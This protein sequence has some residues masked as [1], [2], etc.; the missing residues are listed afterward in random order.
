[1]EPD[2]KSW[3][4]ATAARLKLKQ[5]TEEELNVLDNTE[6]FDEEWEKVLFRACQRDPYLSNSTFK[7]SDLLNLIA[8]QLPEGG[9][10]EETVNDLLALSSV[11]NVEAS[12]QVRGGEGKYQRT[13]YEG[14]NGYT[15]RLESDGVEQNYIE[16]LEYIHG[17]IKKMFADEEDVNFLYSATGGVTLYAQGKMR[18]TKFAGLNYSGLGRPHIQIMLLKDFRN[19]FK[20]PRIDN[21]EITNVRSYKSKNERK[22]LPF[23]EFYLIKLKDKSEYSD[24]IKDLIKASFEVR[25]NNLKILKKGMHAVKMS[26]DEDDSTASSEIMTPQS[27]GESPVVGP[28]ERFGEQ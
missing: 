6:E 9:D 11:T 15:Q 13:L 2:F 14:I 16:F 19:G 5:L 26:I 1:M 22:N 28:S 3:D 25:Q 4:E 27:P 17:D 7:I 10:L 24:A 18:G 20:K 8:S 23:I 12:D 21:L